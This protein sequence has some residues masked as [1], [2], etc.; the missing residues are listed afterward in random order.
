MVHLYRMIGGDV[1]CD[2]IIG[3]LEKGE[4]YIVD[5]W[6]NGRK[7]MDGRCVDVLSM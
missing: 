1:K 3:Y 2:D 7:D 5:D 4:G 6:G